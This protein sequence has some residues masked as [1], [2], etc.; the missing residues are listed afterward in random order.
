MARVR[1]YLEAHERRERAR[2]EEARH[3]RARRRALWLAVHGVDFGPSLI[4]GVKVGA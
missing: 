4:H 2:R 1:P 3:Q